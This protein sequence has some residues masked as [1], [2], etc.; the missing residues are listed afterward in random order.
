M[1]STSKIKVLALTVALLMLVLPAL[2][3]CEDFFT[4]PYEQAVND[5]VK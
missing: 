2:A 1:K 5:N 3:S 4:A